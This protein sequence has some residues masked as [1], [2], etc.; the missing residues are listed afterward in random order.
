MLIS[1]YLMIY[2]LIIIYFASFLK[3]FPMFIRDR[4]PLKNWLL[5]PL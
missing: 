4:Q 3:K 1:V 2:L 5:E